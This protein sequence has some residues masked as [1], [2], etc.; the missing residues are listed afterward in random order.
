MYMDKELLEDKLDQIIDKFSVRKIASAKF[1]SIFKNKKHTVYDRNENIMTGTCKVQFV[2][3]DRIRQNVQ[4]IL[5]Y[6]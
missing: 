5:N 6:I 4:T 1:Y 3:D 2:N